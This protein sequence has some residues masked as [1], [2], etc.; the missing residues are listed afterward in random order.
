MELDLFQSI[1]LLLKNIVFFVGENIAVLVSLGALVV[2]AFNV[3]E[4]RKQRVK[5]YEPILLL[6]PIGWDSAS[7][8]GDLTPYIKVKNVGY[9]TAL[10]IKC[11][12]ELGK[13]LNDSK[14][15]EKTSEMFVLYK[16]PD[17]E[18]GKL[19]TGAINKDLDFNKKFEYQLPISIE[20]KYLKLYI[21]YIP[22]LQ[23]FGQLRELKGIQQNDILNREISRILPIKMKLNVKYK[24][25]NR[26]SSIDKYEIDAGL[27]MFSFE[28]DKINLSISL[29]SKH[30][31]KQNNYFK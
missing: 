2:T 19:S 23:L 3:N 15:L 7:S 4:V 26:K 24:D 30:V 20:E 25:I 1:F 8:N 18:S 16:V 28:G 17:I 14:Y 29:E 12:W 5:M 11:E 13:V 6:E 22:I 31:E 9:G 27:D 10:D 21:P